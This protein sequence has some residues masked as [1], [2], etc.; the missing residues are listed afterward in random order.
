MDITEAIDILKQKSE[1][2]WLEFKQEV[3]IYDSNNKII[4]TARDEFIKDIIGLA[5]G[6]SNIVRKTKYLVIGADNS[7][8]DS[9]GN[10]LLY[11]IS[12]YFPSQSEITKWLNNSC[13]PSIVG[14]QCNN[15][16]IENKN[17]YI[18]SIPPSLELHETTRTLDAK[19]TF[20]EHTVFIRRD[21]HTVIASVEDIITLR[22]LKTLYRQDINNPP[23]IIFGAIIGIVFSYIFFNMGY[24]YNK[25]NN[26]N[27]DSL[28]PARIIIIV[29][30]GIMGAWIGRVF[31]EGNSFRYNWRYWTIREK[32]FNI[33]FY[34]A[35]IA[36]ATIMTILYS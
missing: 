18:I 12:H 2:D 19:G 26:L 11:D 8:F 28:L 33:L 16:N 15:Y 13:S 22:K 10:R 7:K 35:V 24:F 21:E 34:I 5:N 30:G 9:K 31:R 25:S 36:F 17:I 29:F 20:H 23:A 1:Q 4:T 6:N 32:I 27:T 3:I 14:I